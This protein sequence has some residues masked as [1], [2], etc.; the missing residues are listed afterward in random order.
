VVVLT[1]RVRSRQIHRTDRDDELSRVAVCR[2]G[3]AD[4]LRCERT[5]EDA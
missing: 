4:L 3:G 5:R 1:A 2:E